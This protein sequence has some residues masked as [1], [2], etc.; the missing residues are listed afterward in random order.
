MKKKLGK[1]LEI[2][3]VIFIIAVTCKMTGIF[4]AVNGEF[5]EVSAEVKDY[6][7][8]SNVVKQAVNNYEDSITV[9]VKDF[10]QNKYYGDSM[11]KILEDNIKETLNDAIK[12]YKITKYGIFN[13]ILKIDFKYSESTEELKRKEKLVNE[14]VQEIVKNTITS[15]MG[16]YEKEKALYSYL[17]NNCEYDFDTYNSGVWDKNN[18][19]YSALINKLSMCQ[20][21]AQAMNRLLKAVNIESKIISGN[22]I[23]DGIADDKSGH[24]W[25]IV[26]VNGKYYHIDATWDSEY[27]D[28]YSESSYEFFNLTD[29]EIE[30]SRK[31]DRKSYPACNEL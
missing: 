16:E 23:D 27:T 11:K 5:G 14:K 4:A 6:S 20:G 1:L 26:K 13:T 25:N 3:F 24:A 31:W 8:Y 9:K 2:I 21:Y 10:D 7:E 12:E 29:K 18:D 22:V 30:Y 28:R 17:I 15:D 19:E